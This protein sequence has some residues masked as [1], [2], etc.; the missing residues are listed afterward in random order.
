[1]N[2]RDLQ[3]IEFIYLVKIRNH[4]QDV[5]CENIMRN[6]KRHNILIILSHTQYLLTSL[7][8]TSQKYKPNETLYKVE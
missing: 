8:K 2:L 7:T 1:M 4:D 6:L 5:L 3:T